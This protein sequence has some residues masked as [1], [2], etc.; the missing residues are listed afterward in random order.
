MK[1]S[2]KQFEINKTEQ[3]WKESLTPEQ[4]NV[5]RKHGT[6]RAGTSPLDKEYGEGVYKCA[7]C[8]KILFTS[9][10]K[11]NSGTGWPSFYKPIEG[12]IETSV[13]RSLFM[14]RTEVHCSCCGGHLGHV[15]GDGPKPTGQRY[16]MNGVSLE[17]I[18]KGE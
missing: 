12:A 16:C 9:E 6:E 15:F 17:F 8:D 10:T 14:T 5:L 18:P 13:D 1:T 4:F 7:A 11:Y 3:E 2:D